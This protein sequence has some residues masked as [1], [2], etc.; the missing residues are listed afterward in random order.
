MVAE[1]LRVSI[2]ELLKVFI[3]NENLLSFV[4][5]VLRYDILDSVTYCHILCSK[6]E[7]L[8]EISMNYGNRILVRI[9]VPCSRGM[10]LGLKAVQCL[11]LLVWKTAFSERDK[12]KHKYNEQ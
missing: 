3:I 11:G 6:P 8:E 2:A 1:L 9:L 10:E 4:S 7:D 5:P 12:A